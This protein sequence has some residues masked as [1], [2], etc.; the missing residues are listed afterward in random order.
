MSQESQ[1]KAKM[2]AQ[3]WLGFLRGGTD[4]YDLFLRYLREDVQKGGFCLEDIDTNETE[5]EELRVKQACQA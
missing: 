1:T 4:S 3:K 2:D 5:L